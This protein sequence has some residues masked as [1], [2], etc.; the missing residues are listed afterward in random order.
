[1]VARQRPEQIELVGLAPRRHMVTPCGIGRATRAYASVSPCGIRP[2]SRLVRAG[3][4]TSSYNFQT[5]SRFVG[6][7]DV[8]SRF[9]CRIRPPIASRPGAPPRA[10]RGPGTRGLCMSTDV[11]A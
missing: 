9:S 5:A 1:V 10:R 6:S 7:R 2:P 8:S 11:Y 4:R 3:L